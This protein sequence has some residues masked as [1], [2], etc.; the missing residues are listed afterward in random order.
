MQHLL[1][2]VQYRSNY[3]RYGDVYTAAAFD[4]VLTQM[5]MQVEKV[6]CDIREHG[7]VFM[8]FQLHQINTNI[9]ITNKQMIT[10]MYVLASAGCPYARSEFITSTRAQTLTHCGM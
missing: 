7:T 9:S 10:C 3:P 6:K 4:D 5:M 1:S 8:P 2:E